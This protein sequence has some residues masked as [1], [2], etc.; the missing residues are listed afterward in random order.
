MAC[1][2]Y[3]NDKCQ[4]ICNSIILMP[5]VVFFSGISFVEMLVFAPF[6]LWRH[7]TGGNFE[8]IYETIPLFSTFQKFAECK[9]FQIKVLQVPW[10]TKSI[11]LTNFR[12]VQYKKNMGLTQIRT[13]ISSYYTNSLNLSKKLI[14]YVIHISQDKSIYLFIYLSWNS[15]QFCL[16]NTRNRL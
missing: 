4:D 12:V 1:N 10:K 6:F 2:W 7:S 16:C 5:R 11:E 15:I 8:F 13:I 3:C 9:V 14:H